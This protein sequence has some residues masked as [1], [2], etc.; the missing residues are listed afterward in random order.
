M[1]LIFKLIISLYIPLF[2]I[3]AQFLSLP[4]GAE[5]LALGSHPT[6]ENYFSVN[7]A[8]YVVADN[9]PELF[10]DRGSWFG[11]VKIAN[12][13][14]HQQIKKIVF[15]LKLRYTGLS[16]IELRDSRPSDEALAH[17]SAFGVAGN[18]GFSIE[19]NRSRFGLS[20]EAIRMDVFT[21]SSEG[22]SLNIGYLYKVSKTLSV[23]TSFLNIGKMSSLQNISPKLPLR[24]FFGL[25]KS[26]QFSEYY[27]KIYISAEWNEYSNAIRMWAGNELSWKRLRVMGGG[28][29]SKETHTIS[30]GLGLQ[31][32]N[33]NVSYAIRYGS[34]DLG[35]PHSISLRLLFP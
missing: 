9:H 33:Y 21:E 1:H 7:P 3:G 17:F 6:C 35:I 11:D 8:A 10:L 4:V 19:S 31:F 30:G 20:L 32:G 2:G 34:Q 14:F 28:S 12:I 22:L 24:I 13:A 29:L 5:E 23:A 15:H 18:T 26:L 27:N 16:K 25:G